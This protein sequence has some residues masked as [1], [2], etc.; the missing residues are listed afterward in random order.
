MMTVINAGYSYKQTCHAMEIFTVSGQNILMAVR[1]GL[2]SVNAL[3][4]VGQVRTEKF[5]PIPPQMSANAD[6]ISV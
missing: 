5:G 6:S 3:S 2:G 4:D 1:F